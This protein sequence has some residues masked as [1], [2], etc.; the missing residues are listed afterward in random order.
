MIPGDQ[1]GSKET[2]KEARAAV[3]IRDGNGLVQLATV[4]KFRVCCRGRINRTYLKIRYKI[5]KNHSCL[6][7]KIELKL[8]TFTEISYSNGEF[9]FKC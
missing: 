5:D 8:E 1:N 9:G 2:D 6:A 3:H 4:E 7:C